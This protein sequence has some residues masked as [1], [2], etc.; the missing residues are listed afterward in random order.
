[1]ASAL[2]EASA[3]TEA[4]ELTEA[5]ALTLLDFSAPARAPDPVPMLV[6]TGFLGAGKTTLLMSIAGALGPWRGSIALAG[7]DITHLPDYQRARSG[8]VL[9]PQGRPLLPSLTA[10]ENIPIP[11]GAPGRGARRPRGGRP[12]RRAWGLHP[13]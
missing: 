2:I 12:P 4:G 6:L 10:Q 3:R 13:S 5:E 7:P 9:E 11:A 1:M 8:V